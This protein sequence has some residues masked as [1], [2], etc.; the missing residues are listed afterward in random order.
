MA[1]TPDHVRLIELLAR[2]AVDELVAQQEHAAARL[3]A[4]E[5]RREDRPSTRTDAA[6]R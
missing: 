3:T 4:G 1:L 6:A 2:R 5:R